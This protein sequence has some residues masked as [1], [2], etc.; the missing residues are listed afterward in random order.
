MQPNA[1]I[2]ALVQMSAPW[3]LPR[4]Y[5]L[6]F[7]KKL[8]LLKGSQSFLFSQNG[9]MYTLLIVWINKATGSQFEEIP[10]DYFLDWIGCEVDTSFVFNQPWDRP[11]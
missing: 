9:F 5:K 4:K 7:S 11:G 8:W 6:F 10:L 3:A 2:V 1:R